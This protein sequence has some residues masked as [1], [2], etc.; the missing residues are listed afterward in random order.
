[1]N[2]GGNSPKAA[3]DHKTPSSSCEQHRGAKHPLRSRPAP[4]DGLGSARLCCGG[5]SLGSRLLVGPTRSVLSPAE[6]AS[7]PR[8]Q[9][10]P[11]AR[12]EKLRKQD[13][14]QRELK[15]ND[16][17]MAV[18]F[19]LERNIAARDENSSELHFYL[20]LKNTN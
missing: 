7:V 18:L 10:F 16:S 11:A 17:P 5:A 6:A 2:W 1:M 19:L 14:L 15:P 3:V 9:P 13:R 4:G 12:A 20:L 8:E